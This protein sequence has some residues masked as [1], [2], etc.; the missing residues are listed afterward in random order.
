MGANR[1]K[2]PA[3]LRY[4]EREGM[5]SAMNATKWRD[6]LLQFHHLGKRSKRTRH[7]EEAG[8][9]PEG[10]LPHSLPHQFTHAL[11]L[12]R[13]RLAVGEADHRFPH[14][15]LADEALRR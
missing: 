8:A 15:P 2:K 6:D 1:R 11:K 12:V 14:S 3:W 4:A 9:E 5:T 13:R 10:A 7:V